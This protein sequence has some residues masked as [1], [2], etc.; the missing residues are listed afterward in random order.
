MRSSASI[1]SVSMSNYRENDENSLNGRHTHFYIQ[2]Y[3]RIGKNTLQS[4]KLRSSYPSW[5]WLLGVLY[6]F[7]FA[8]K[9]QLSVTLLTCDFESY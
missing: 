6:A 3:E 2:Y 5:F 8:T 9:F 4:S 1:A 7:N